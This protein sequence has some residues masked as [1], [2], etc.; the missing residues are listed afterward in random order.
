MTLNTDD[1][2]SFADFHIGAGDTILW[3]GRPERG[4]TFRPNNIAM[5]PFGIFF[6]AFA[7]F[8]MSM[9]A[10]AFPPF[11]IFGLPFVL[12]GLYLAGGK[13]I[14]DECMKGR[15]AYVITNKAIIRKRGNRVDVWRGSDLSDMQVCTH[16]NG[17]A[18]FLFRNSVINRGRYY[19][20]SQEYYGIENVRDVKG[21]SEAINKIER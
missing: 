5:I 19:R 12:I 6:A 20:V 7:V 16:R 10:S 14:V 21:V 17:T 2:Y 3:K 4:I 1:D 11:A 15:T 18:S 8:W 13:L 9:A